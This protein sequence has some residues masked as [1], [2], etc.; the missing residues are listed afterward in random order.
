MVM[1]PFGV[2]RVDAAAAGAVVVGAA[3]AGV[4]AG[5][6]EVADAGVAAAA[7]V[8]AGASVAAGADV[9]VGAGVAAGVQASSRL[10]R[11]VNNTAV[12]AARHLRRRAGAV[13]AS[14]MTRY[15]LKVSPF[16]LVGCR[17]ARLRVS[18][19]MLVLCYPLPLSSAQVAIRKDGS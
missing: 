14:L 2:G 18:P 4:A 12:G 6:A 5:L 17:A 9:A 15:T 3:A 19:A 8:A 1:A 10:V 7:D 13:R 16:S 11:N